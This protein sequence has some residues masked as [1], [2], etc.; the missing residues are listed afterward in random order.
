[1]GGMLMSCC[2]TRTRFLDV[3]RCD[4]II[5]FNL[6]TRLGLIAEHGFWVKPAAAHHIHSGRD[7]SKT[8]WDETTSSKVSEQFVGVEEWEA[9]RG[10]SEGRFG[11]SFGSINSNHTNKSWIGTPA[12]E[13]QSTSYKSRGHRRARTLPGAGPPSPDGLSRQQVGDVARQ[14]GTGPGWVLCSYNADLSWRGEVRAILENFTSRTPGS[15]LELKD[16]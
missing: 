7:L 5:S 9:D 4:N 1:M 11:E 15:F 3:R 14:S 16:R 10:G 13:K 8:R 12:G 2:N 6:L